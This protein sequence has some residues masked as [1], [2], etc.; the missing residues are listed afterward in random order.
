MIYYEEPVIRPPAEADSL[1]LQATIGCSH[2]K[3][4]FC[5][6]YKQK[7]FRVR[8]FEHIKH[9]IDWAA[10]E[11]PH[12]R[13]VFLGDGDALA[14]PTDDLV[15][16][17]EYLYTTLPALKKVAVYASPGNFENKS[18]PELQRLKAAGLSLLYIGFE[19]G[20]DDTLLRIKKG[21][22]A[23]EMATL[24][25]KPNEAGLKISATVIL[26]L[27]GPSDMQR[28]GENTAKLIDKVSPRFASALTLMLPLGKKPYQKHW[29][30]NWRMLTPRESLQELRFLVNAVQGNKIIFRSNHAS[31]YLPIE[32]TF[33][34]GKAKML[35]QIDAALNDQR[36]LRPEFLRG[37]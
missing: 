27:G 17:L 13:K 28:R 24:M 7:K 37:L 31:N 36:A 26:G 14:I 22:T 12:V 1:I 15:Q 18:V 10:K 35:D 21:F 5:I 4:T 6:T 3:C 25:E 34:K 33:Q 30:P 8:P 2:N 23:N 11:I 19:S 32:G 29:D 16:I 20:D 9:E